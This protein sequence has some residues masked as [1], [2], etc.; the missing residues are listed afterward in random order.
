MK[1][2]ESQ[3]EKKYTDN[4]IG[5]V[6]WFNRTYG[7]IVIMDGKSSGMDAYVHYTDILSSKHIYKYLLPGEYIECNIIRVREKNGME[8]Y[9]AKNV[10][11]VNNNKLYCE[12]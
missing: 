12:L 11:G 7:Y 10:R 9:Y 2:H 5:R 8:K 4:F 1:Y 6:Q 3:I